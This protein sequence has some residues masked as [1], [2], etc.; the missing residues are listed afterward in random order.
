MRWRKLTLRRTRGTQWLLALAVAFTHAN[1]AAG[2]SARLVYSR[3]DDAES[4]GDEQGLRRAVARRLGY[5]PFVAASMNTVVADLRAEGDGLKARVYLIRDGN[6]AGGS[7]EL[8]SPKRDCTELLAAVA[9]AISIA[10]DPDALDR[11]EPAEQT[12]RTEAESTQRPAS[13]PPESPSNAPPNALPTPTPDTSAATTQLR[14]VA[15]WPKAPGTQAHSKL[16]TSFDVGIG[17]YGA[18]GPAPFLSTGG[19][20]NFGVRFGDW[21]LWLQ[22]ELSLP[23]E[24][25]PMAGATVRARTYGCSVSAG[26]WLEGL[27]VGALFDAIAL[28]ARGQGVELPSQNTVFH[29]GAGARVGYRFDLGNRFALVPS[30]DGLVSLRR[31]EMQLNH[32][33]SYTS[34]N[35]FA[36]LGASIEYRF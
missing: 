7:R 1:A 35:A 4:C 9:L 26:Y 27:Y 30:I 11:A 34:P 5:D 13:S 14:Q 19:W 22:P 17:A 23:S 3:T 6:I 10:V 33:P 36:R 12:S 24:S 2:Q 31:V 25:N 18:T 29:A 15:V 32:R 16:S 20:L 21:Q 28:S 8:S